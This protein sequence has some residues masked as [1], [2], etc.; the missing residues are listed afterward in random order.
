MSISL[1]SGQHLP[2][3]GLPASTGQT[4]TTDSFRGKMPVVFVFL[5][6]LE[7]DVNVSLLEDLNEHLSDFGSERSQIL[8]VVKEAART[9][10]SRTDEMGIRFPILADAAGEMSR[11]FGVG[12]AE[13][14][15]QPVIVIADREGRLVRGF[16]PAPVE[17]LVGAALTTIRGLGSGAVMAH[18]SK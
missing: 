4:L 2:D 10:R 9:V 8:G 14:G 5:S 3:Y 16:D 12:F 17:G 18:D 1:K 15:E 11:E 13:E 6:D 7:S